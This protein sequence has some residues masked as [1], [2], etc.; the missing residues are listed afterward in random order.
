MTRQ[1]WIVLAIA[2]I[3]TVLASLNV[4]ME[5]ALQHMSHS[6]AEEL[7]ADGKAEHQRVLD[8]VAEHAQ[9]K[10]L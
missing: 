6:K 10:N 4:A 5:T 1:E 7:A 9:F 8:M 2:F 3:F